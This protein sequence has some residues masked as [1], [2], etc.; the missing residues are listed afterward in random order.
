MVNFWMG[1]VD[2]RLFGLSTA[3]LMKKTKRVIPL[4]TL[5]V[6]D[7]PTQEQGD[8]QSEVVRY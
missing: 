8:R 4:E 3:A 5:G 1:G 6:F 2:Q 7:S